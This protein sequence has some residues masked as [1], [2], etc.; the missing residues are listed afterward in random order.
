MGTGLT[1][2][3]AYKNR[4]RSGRVWPPRFNTLLLHLL[5]DSAPLLLFARHGI[6]HAD[7]LNSQRFGTLALSVRQL[8]IGSRDIGDGPRAAITHHEL[9][10][11]LENFQHALHSRLAECP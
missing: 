11:A 3:Q 4:T 7:Y 1:G 2:G 8:D 10:F 6:S 5:A 9:E